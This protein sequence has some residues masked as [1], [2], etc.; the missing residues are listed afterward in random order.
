MHLITAGGGFWG[1]KPTAVFCTWFFVLCSLL[2]FEYRLRK[3][4][5]TKSKGQSYAG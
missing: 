1:A 3:E 4:Q 2:D 5:K